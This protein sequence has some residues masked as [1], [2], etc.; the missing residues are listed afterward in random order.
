M[1]KINKATIALSRHSCAISTTGVSLSCNTGTSYKESYKNLLIN[2]NIDSIPNNGEDIAAV[3][4]QTDFLKQSRVRRT[5]RFL[6]GPIPLR[7]ICVAA[8]LSG[9][10]LALFLAIH[11]QVALTG[12]SIVTL[13]AS[14]L[15]DLGIT[16][17]T[18]ARCLSAL[19]QASLVAVSRSRGKGARMRLIRDG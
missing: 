5:G 17:S 15:R 12:K 19:E 16:R 4:I 3:E 8:K 7:D 11:H 10:C 2:N 1:T 13:P 6:K 9:K 18:K 14:L